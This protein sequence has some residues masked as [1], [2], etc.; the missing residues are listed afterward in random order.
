M[1]TFINVAQMKLASLKEGQFVETGGYYTK[2]DAGQA[3]YLIVAAQAADGYGDHTLVNGTV[4]VLHKVWPINALQ[5]GVAGAN[6]GAQNTAALQACFD[7]LPSFNNIFSSASAGVVKLPSE[8]SAGSVLAFSFDTTGGEL[9]LHGGVEFIGDKTTVLNL[10]A[11]STLIG[12]KDQTT[13]V[14]QHITIRDMT[15][16]KDA[17]LD[18]A[19]TVGIDLLN[20]SYALLENLRIR[21]FEKGIRAGGLSTDAING[22]FYNNFV[23]LEVANCDWAIFTEFEF[24]S[25][26]VVGGRYL[27]NKIG[28]SLAGCSDNYISAAFE[29]TNLA[30]EMG[31]GARSNTV[32][33]CRF[34]SCGR[35]QGGGGD[36]DLLTGGAIYFH[37]NSTQNTVLGGHYSGSGDKIIDEG[38]A[39]TKVGSTSSAGGSAGNATA[40]LFGNP[41]LDVDSNS[42][43]LAD[44]LVSTPSTGVTL[45]IDAINHRVGTASQKIA[46]DATNVTR[47]DVTTSIA[48]QAGNTYT[49][50]TLVETSVD[51]GWNIRIGKTVTGTDFANVAINE[52]PSNGDGFNLIQLTFLADDSILLGQ[53]FVYINFFMN[54]ATVGT[55]ANLAIDYLS[56]VQGVGTALS[57]NNIV[58][59]AQTVA[60]I[61]TANVSA[62]TLSYLPELDR[63]ATI[64]SA[65]DIRNAAGRKVVGTDDNVDAASTVVLPAGRNCVIIN[66]TGTPTNIDNITTDDDAIVMLLIPSSQVTLTD[67]GNKRLS[68]PFVGG[69]NDMISLGCIRGVWYEI[70][71]SAN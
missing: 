53:E 1:K 66:T 27:S 38:F 19:G 30:I 59:G 23:Q 4:A 25:N 52:T 14:N 26:R 51:S 45:S 2:G 41:A 67:G 57:N 55:V 62:G 44:G 68:A 29:K 17:G 20:C 12:T 71:R 39:N 46:I 35:S 31:D 5:Y 60:G 13:V 50:S 16:Q 54:S 7:A 48:V 70:G 8:S 6:T 32:A 61:Q 10:T 49:V 28:I 34:E 9:L 18:I 47:R 3:K 58:L 24:N 11:G 40:N 65:G 64:D 33:Q 37:P 22:G 42:D 43:G 15:I 36:V 69:S 56:I 21:T 63:I